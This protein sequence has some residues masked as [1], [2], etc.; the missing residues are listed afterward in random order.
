M[1][2]KAAG[3]HFSEGNRIYYVVNELFHVELARMILA[4]EDYHVLWIQD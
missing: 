4:A 3:T 2:E 1:L